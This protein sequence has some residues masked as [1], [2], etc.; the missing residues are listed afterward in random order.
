QRCLGADSRRRHL[1][2]WRAFCF[3]FDGGIYLGILNPCSMNGAQNAYPT[4]LM[5]RGRVGYFFCAPSCFLSSDIILLIS[6]IYQS[7]YIK[8]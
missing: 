4:G 8:V 3:S 6:A 2:G 7:T 5:I 1:N